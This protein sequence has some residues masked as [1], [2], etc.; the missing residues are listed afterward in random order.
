MPADQVDGS[1]EHDT[2]DQK[3]VN[4]P[5]HS[6]HFSSES[7]LGNRGVRLHHII[8][9]GNGITKSGETTKLAPGQKSA[10]G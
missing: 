2:S 3:V 7:A 5:N 1:D 4:S 10:L 9:G 6:P 8:A